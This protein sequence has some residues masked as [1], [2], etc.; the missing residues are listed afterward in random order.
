M[1]KMKGLFKRSI[2]FVKLCS[3]K[4]KC[5]SASSKAENHPENRNSYV[6]QKSY[7]S[8]PFIVWVLK[9]YEVKTESDQEALSAS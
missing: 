1:K 6:W 7:I 2:K 4:D 3:S 5:L 9:M 8:L